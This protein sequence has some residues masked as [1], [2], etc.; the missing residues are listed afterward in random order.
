MG[1]PHLTNDFT[2]LMF[3][4]CLL[5]PSALQS[6]MQTLSGPSPSGLFVPGQNHT[7]PDPQQ[8]PQEQTILCLLPT[9]KHYLGRYINYLPSPTSSSDFLKTAF[10][11]TYKQQKV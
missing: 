2:A 9:T 7:G 6:E 11:K 10:A 5:F 1:H 4:V 8:S 3:L